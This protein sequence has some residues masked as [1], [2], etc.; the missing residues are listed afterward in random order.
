MTSRLVDLVLYIYYRLD[1]EEANTV[2]AALS[3]WSA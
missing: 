3:S 1:S 2:E